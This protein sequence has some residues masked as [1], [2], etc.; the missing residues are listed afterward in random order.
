MEITQ[1]TVNKL[2]GCTSIL[3]RITKDNVSIEL[4]KEDIRKIS[5]LQNQK[6]YIGDIKWTLY[7]YICD[8][9]TTI[10]HVR[11]GNYAFEKLST[12]IKQDPYTK[13]S[14]DNFIGTLNGE[15]ITVQKNYK[16]NKK[17]II[18]SSDDTIVK[19]GS[20]FDMY[21]DTIYSEDIVLYF[22]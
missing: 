11:C 5:D 20:E 6:H 2:L 22:A 18:I 10:V 7:Q 4:S 3:T 12:I 17:Q 16:M 21:S 14:S 15:D 9:N 19:Y 1:T 13:P 8:M